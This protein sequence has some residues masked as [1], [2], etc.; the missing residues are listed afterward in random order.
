MNFSQP[1]AFW[2]LILLPLALVLAVARE[3]FSHRV[4]REFALPISTV[5]RWRST[6]RITTGCFALLA[7]IIALS[8]PQFQ[9]MVKD[10][11]RHQMKLA[12]GLDVS[13]SML[14]EDVSSSEP[15]EVA[16]RLN[17]GRHFARRLFE[18]LAGEQ[19]G[20][21]FF[22]R[23]GIEV[24][25]PTRDQGFLRYMVQHTRLAELTESGSDLQAAMISGAA[26]LGNHD[27]QTTGAII[28]ISDGEDTENNL[29]ELTKQSERM[30]MNNRPVFTIG[31]GRPDEVYIPIRR[32][33]TEGIDGFYTDTAGHHLRTR[34]QPTTLQTIATSSGG[35]Y[36]A[37]EEITPSELANLLPVVIPHVAKANASL[38]KT[39]G[40]R[41][42]TPLLAAIGLAFYAA[43]CLL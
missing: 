20:L 13:K 34:L 2:L 37:M 16:N 10:D 33:G 11:P 6:A 21:F 1:T 23:N 43:H 28:L 18:E 31:V 25:A 36:F 27:S 42:W 14:A 4:Q 38:P 8:G 41:D 5:Q 15:G 26:L 9:G 3:R 17:A 19:A 32:P 40:L 29:A 39:R 7:L 22:A 24:V 35:R 30:K 12:V